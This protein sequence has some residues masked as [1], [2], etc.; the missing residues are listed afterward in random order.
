M[1]IAFLLSGRWVQMIAFACGIALGSA[2]GAVIMGLLWAS[3][4]EQRPS[5]PIRSARRF[6]DVRVTNVAP[7]ALSQ[8]ALLH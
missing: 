3:D 8:P 7:V 2:F 6:D 5:V 1:A 4:R